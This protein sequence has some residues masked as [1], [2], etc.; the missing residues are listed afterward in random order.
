MIS[1]SFD[2]EVLD[3]ELKNEIFYSLIMRNIYNYVY[4]RIDSHRELN[5]EH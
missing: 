1:N 4:L 2:F 3:F 5:Y